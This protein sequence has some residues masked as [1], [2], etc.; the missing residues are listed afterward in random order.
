MNGDIQ[1]GG[2]FIADDEFGL[3]GEGAGNADALALPAREFVGKA[4]GVLFCKADAEEELFNLTAEVRTFCKTMHQQR[5][6]DD[7]ADTMARIERTG[8]VLEDD[9]HLPAK[10]TQR[11]ATQIENWFSIEVNTA[12]GG[13][14]EAK[15]GP[16]Y[17]GFAAAG[18]ADNAE[19]LAGLNGETYA[20]NGFDMV[21]DSSQ[22]AA[23][24]REMD[25]QIFDAQQRTCCWSVFNCDSCIS[26]C[27]HGN[28]AGLRGR[29]HP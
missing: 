22:H 29:P 18:F 9:L 15:D 6:A 16:T 13:G 11:L 2:W 1:C 21:D 8:G 26:H 17:G 7:F 10:T 27:D 5:F 4:I 23:P 3:E 28:Q 24:H 12:V 20:I 19:G 25:L 14:N